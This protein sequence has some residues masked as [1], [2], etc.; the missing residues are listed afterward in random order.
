MSIVI[1]PILAYPAVSGRRCVFTMDDG[2]EYVILFDDTD[3]KLRIY[4]KTNGSFSEQ[5]AADAP[6][7]LE[8]GAWDSRSDGTKIHFVL[9]GSATE[10]QYVV[11]DTSTDQWGTPESVASGFL[12]P[13]T[14]AAAISL[15]SLDKPH[16]L[17]TVEVAVKG[18]PY[19]Q[20][21]YK[22]KVGASWS[23]EEDALTGESNYLWPICDHESDDRFVVIATQQT[24]TFPD[25]FALKCRTR[26]SAGVWDT[27]G[28]VH[29]STHHYQHSCV[30]Q[31]DNKIAVAVWDSGNKLD[32]MEG[33]A[34]ANPTWST[35]LSDFA[36]IE[37]TSIAADGTDLYVLYEP[38]IQLVRRISGAWDSESEVLQSGSN[39]SDP[40]IEFPMPGADFDYAWYQMFGCRWDH[41][42]AAPPPAPKEGYLSQII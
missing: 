38:S 35:S 9:Y 23:A 1:A 32:V 10:V 28:Q 29:S 13:G 26:S 2:D 24:G 20:V 39:E 7:A 17:Y 12:A 41:W 33:T 42:P 30:V 36:T 31:S 25:T 19:D 11:F 34:G 6:S 5:D 22:N 14:H 3:S 37:G 18:T 40:N 16:V 4:K 15:D 27:E 21:K 8:L